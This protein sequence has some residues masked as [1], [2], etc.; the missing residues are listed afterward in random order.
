MEVSKPSGRLDLDQGGD[1]QK[2]L[3]YVHPGGAQYICLEV[4]FYAYTDVSGLLQR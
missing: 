1:L 4:V 3:E 2:I